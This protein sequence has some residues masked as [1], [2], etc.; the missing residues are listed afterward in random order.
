MSIQDAVGKDNVIQHSDNKFTLGLGVGASDSANG[1]ESELAS[2][3]NRRVYVV[4]FDEVI[5]NIN[6]KWY[7]KIKQIPYLYDKIPEMQKAVLEKHPS[8]RN[9][10]YIAPY[11]G[12][13]EEDEKLCNNLFFED[14]TFYDDLE[15][16]P[17]YNQLKFLVEKG[18][19]K[20]I[21]IVTSC[22]WSLDAPVN[23]NKKKKIES[24]FNQ[25]TFP[26]CPVHIHM[27]T[28]PTKKADYIVEKGIIPNVIVE[29]SDKNL[30]EYLEANIVRCE[31]LVPMCLYAVKTVASVAALRLLVEKECHISIFDNFDSKYS[32]DE[33]FMMEVS[34]AYVYEKFRVFERDL[35]ND[36]EYKKDLEAAFQER[37]ENLTK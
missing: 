19:V 17:F 16:A 23:I 29:D 2:A 24:L 10:F 37:K 22:G 8:L 34:K 21:H 14:P 25:A 1:K 12:F 11:I 30:K 5:V 6:P 33:I 28:Y 35:A 15:P 32:Q 3:N 4:D 36:P 31:Y 26:A 7:Q 13:N 9:Q 18:L 27:L 20:E